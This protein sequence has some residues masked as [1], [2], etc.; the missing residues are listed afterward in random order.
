MS[1]KLISNKSVLY[2]AQTLQSSVLTIICPTLTFTSKD[3]QQNQGVDHSVG[4]NGRLFANYDTENK[5]FLNVMNYNIPSSEWD[6][7]Y[8]NQTFTSNEPFDKDMECALLYIKQNLSVI[9]GLTQ[10]DWVFDI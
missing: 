5:V 3:M 9:Y 7:F 10:S 6:T 4:I 2:N 8:S 1:H